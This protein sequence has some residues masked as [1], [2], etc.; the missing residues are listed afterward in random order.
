[1]IPRTSIHNSF[2]PNW[3]IFLSTIRLIQI[4][5]NK[6]FLL[7]VFE[8]KEKNQWLIAVNERIFATMPLSLKRNLRILLFLE[9]FSPFCYSFLDY[10]RHKIETSVLI[11]AFSSIYRIFLETSHYSSNLC[12]IWPQLYFY[13]YF[14]FIQKIDLFFFLFGIM[15]LL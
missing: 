9:S 13:F 4:N 8:T 6:R 5:Y 12:W 10:E 11:N 2:V 3:N 7:S 15:K 14:I 1:M